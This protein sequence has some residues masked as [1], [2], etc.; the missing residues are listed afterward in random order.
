M[1]YSVLDAEGR[2]I[3]ATTDEGNPT[4]RLRFLPMQT[5]R[6]AFQYIIPIDNPQL[7][8]PD[9]PYLYTLV[10]EVIV[11]GKTVDNKAVRFGVRDVV[12]DKDRGLLLNGTPLK[13]KGVNMH[14]DHAGV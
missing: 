7:W 12:F 14:Q 3:A 4:R 11:G 10:A 13:I 8:S 2:Q 6:S 5:R 9:T 1:R